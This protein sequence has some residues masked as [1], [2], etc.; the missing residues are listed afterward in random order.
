V[1]VEGTFFGNSTVWN[2]ALSNGESIPYVH[3]QTV[4][5]PKGTFTFTNG[6]STTAMTQVACYRNPEF[7]H[8]WYNEGEYM[9]H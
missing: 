3:H 2:Q 1:T 8:W 4:V 6:S 9:Y 7:N 5:D